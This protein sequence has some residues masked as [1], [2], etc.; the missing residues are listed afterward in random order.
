MLIGMLHRRKDPEKVSR[1]YLYASFCKIEGFDFVYFTANDV[2]FKSKTVY[3]QVYNNGKWERKL[4]PFPDYVLNVSFPITP[5]Q[6]D[7]YFKL[8]AL[9][10]FVT[11][12]VGSKLS[13][14]RKIK[15]GNL[16][17]EYLIPYEIIK[18]SLQVFKFIEKHK[19]VIIKPSK[20]NHGKGVIFIEKNNDNFLVKQGFD[21]MYLNGIEMTEFLEPLIELKTMIIQKYISSLRKS[22]VSFDIRAHVQKNDNGN[23]EITMIYPRIAEQGKVVTNLSAGGLVKSLDKFLLDE[24]GED[25]AFNMKR[26]LE[27]F[28]LNFASHFET[29]YKHDFDELGIDLGID[30]NDKI[31]VYE[32]N[33][34]PDRRYLI[35]KGARLSI[36]Y[37]KYLSSQEKGEQDEDTLPK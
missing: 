35:A 20:S 3:G 33:I 6:T 34:R 4:C 2:N 22:G 32:V 12:P 21:N 19:K 5:K 25:E 13:I 15:K 8:K 18:T 28:A 26:Y 30:E 9:T 29:L 7:V 31:W 36:K 37:V 10:K 16:F 23:F 27:V 14:Y 24:Y 11:F 1:S 17:T